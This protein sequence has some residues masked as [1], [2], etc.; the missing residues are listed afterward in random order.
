MR[1]FLSFVHPDVGYT[2]MRAMKPGQD[3][4]RA[5]YWP[6]HAIIGDAVTLDADGWDVY[7]GVLPRQSKAGTADDVVPLAGVLWAD[8]DDHDFEDGHA[9]ALDAVLSFPV[10]ASVLV[11]SGHGFHAYWKLR[12]PVPTKDA[13]LVNQA[14]AKWMG[15]DACF[16]APRILRLPGLHNHKNPDNPIPVRLLKLDTTRLFDLSDFNEMVES[17]SRPVH[18]VI[19]PHERRED[20]PEWLSDLINQDPPKGARSETEFRAG[21]WLARMGYSDEEISSIFLNSP[22][23]AKAQERGERWTQAEVARI[24]RKA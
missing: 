14:V 15:A 23:G 16:D 21:V 8:L 9:G 20:A 2:E 7:A 1:D 17:F 5:F 22:V 12:E 10:P 6:P 11:D 18:H 24:R 3:V 19:T 13:V 4:V